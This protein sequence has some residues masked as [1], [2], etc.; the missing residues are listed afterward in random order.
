MYPLGDNEVFHALYKLKSP[1]R[2]C[3]QCHEI[4]HLKTFDFNV[5]E[6]QHKI[7]DGTHNHI[8]CTGQAEYWHGSK[9]LL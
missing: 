2:A 1:F 7:Y 6:Q 8:I 4:H 5:C 9:G 3:I